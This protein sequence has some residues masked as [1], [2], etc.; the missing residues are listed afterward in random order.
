MKRKDPMK[1]YAMDVEE[2]SDKL[3]KTSK[4]IKNKRNIHDCVQVKFYL[5]EPLFRNQQ[6]GLTSALALSLIL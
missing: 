4:Q 5:H 1:K 2:D 3:T 6:K